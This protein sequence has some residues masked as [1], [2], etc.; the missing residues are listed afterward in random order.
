MIRGWKR[1]KEIQVHQNVKGILL[2]FYLMG[3]VTQ[4]Q[5]PGYGFGQQ[6]HWQ[7][8]DCM[9]LQDDEHSLQSHIE[10]QYSAAKEQTEVIKTHHKEADVQKDPRSHFFK[11]LIWTAG[12][13]SIIKV[14]QKSIQSYKMWYQSYQRTRCGRCVIELDMQFLRTTL[15]RQKIHDRDFEAFSYKYQLCQQ[16]DVTA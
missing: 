9:E 8:C 13:T 2:L 14:F 10:T 4:Y 7:A 15:S 5:Q 12:V 3:H 16:L 11:I 1:V 6:N